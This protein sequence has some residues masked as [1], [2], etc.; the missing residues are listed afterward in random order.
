MADVAH[1]GQSGVINE[2][3]LGNDRTYADMISKYE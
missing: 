1:Q 2:D 3:K